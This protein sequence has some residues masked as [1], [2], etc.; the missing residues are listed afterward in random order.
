MQ[1]RESSKTASM[2]GNIATIS[3]EKTAL[4]AETDIKSTADSVRLKR[5]LIFDII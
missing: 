4:A 2:L 1:A 3:I 5:N